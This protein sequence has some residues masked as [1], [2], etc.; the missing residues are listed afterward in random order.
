MAYSVGHKFNVPISE[1]LKSIPGYF[2]IRL[3][4]E[5][6]YQVI[7]MDADK[8]IRAYDRMTLAS[9]TVSGDYEQAMVEG[10]H[11]L[12]QY[13]FGD[14]ATSLEMQMTTPIYEEQNHNSWTISFILP[15]EITQTTAPTPRDHSITI[16]ERPPQRV[17]VIWYTGGN[18][19]D[20]IYEKSKELYDWLNTLRGYN[21]VGDAKIAQYD[22]PGTLDFFRRNELQVEVAEVH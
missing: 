6:K 14:N 22:G 16:S 9:V 10:Y 17:A 8:E 7:D 3:A 5:P 20:R 4:D 12:S 19:L 13:L 11:R 21:T 2:G 18:D 15:K 1:K